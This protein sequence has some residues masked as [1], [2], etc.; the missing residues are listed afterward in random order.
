MQLFTQM[1]DATKKFHTQYGWIS[2]E[3]W[4]ML[5]AN[6]MKKS[7][8]NADYIRDGDKIGARREGGNFTDFNDE[9]EE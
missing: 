4:C 6:R 8:I 3:D 5:E 2:G 7:G 9:G 1:I